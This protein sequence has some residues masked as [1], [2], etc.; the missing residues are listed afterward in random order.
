LANLGHVIS[1]QTVGNVLRRYGLPPAPER[2]RTTPW[3]VFIQTHL[4]LLAGTGQSG[5]IRTFLQLGLF[6]ALRTKS[7]NEAKR[8]GG[9]Q[10][11]TNSILV[12]SLQA[13]PPVFASVAD[14]A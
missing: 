11:I 5:R 3:S 8:L 13:V 1:D 4:A 7:S 9:L 12:P 14:D 10:I 6:A 2:K